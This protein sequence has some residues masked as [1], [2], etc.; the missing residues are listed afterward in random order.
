MTETIRIG[1]RTIT[2]ELIRK[3]VKNINLHVKA[4]GRIIV[5]ANNRVSKKYIEDFLL[6]KADWIE[7]S[8]RRFENQETG[9][10]TE[11]EPEEGRTIR[12]LGYDYP[13]YIEASPEN[14]VEINGTGIYIHTRFPEDKHRIG[15]LWDKWY[16]TFIK[17]IFYQAV[18]KVYPGFLPYQVPMPVIKIRKMKTRWG[19]CSVYGGM[20]T[21]N[22]AL[23]HAPIECIEY[24]AAH[25]LTHFIHP[26]H[27]SRFYDMLHHIMPDYKERKKLLDRQGIYY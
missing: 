20:I 5:S 21:L 6:R 10:N 14:R 1:D 12:L 13:V 2:Y 11:F 4:D 17:D 25:E 15:L 24:V 3:K 26:N 16:G 8:L 9:Y 19:S 7:K 22:T 18:E 23:I 27:S